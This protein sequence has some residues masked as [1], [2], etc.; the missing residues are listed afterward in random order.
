MSNFCVIILSK[1]VIK[2]AI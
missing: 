2:L 1:H